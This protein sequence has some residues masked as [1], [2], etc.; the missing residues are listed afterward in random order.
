MS[1]ETSRTTA[2]AALVTDRQRCFSAQYVASIAF[3]MARTAE[4]QRQHR[5]FRP[6]LPIPHPLLQNPRALAASATR[7]TTVKSP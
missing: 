6:D 2:L 7:C 5:S 3:H 4:T 1:V